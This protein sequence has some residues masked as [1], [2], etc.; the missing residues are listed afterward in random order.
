M[1]AKNILAGA[2]A[3]TAAMTAFSYFISDKKKVKISG[4]Q[5][6]LPK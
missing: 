1:D 3:G 2:I 4:S 5:P 6:C